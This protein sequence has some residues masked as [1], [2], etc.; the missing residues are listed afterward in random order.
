M[1]GEHLAVD[2]LGVEDAQCL[3][4]EL[5]NRIGRDIANLLEAAVI[6]TMSTRF[7]EP[8]PGCSVILLLNKSHISFHTTTKDH[9]IAMDVFCCS[10]EG[11]DHKVLP[12]LKAHIHHSHLRRWCINRM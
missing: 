5:F 9:I 12:V 7:G 4:I 11:L 6:K 10:A 2:F 8:N 1:E 3:D